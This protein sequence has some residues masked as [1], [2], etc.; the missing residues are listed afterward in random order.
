MCTGSGGW[1]LYQTMFRRTRKETVNSEELCHKENKARYTFILLMMTKSVQRK[2]IKPVAR[3]KG[4]SNL[5]LGS[6]T[7]TLPYYR[8][9]D[10]TEGG[11]WECGRFIF[12]FPECGINHKST[13]NANR[14]KR[15]VLQ[16]KA[17][18]PTTSQNNKLKIHSQVADKMCTWNS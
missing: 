18:T 5:E 1:G 4:A 12:D 13:R 8:T 17:T 10:L 14:A 9:N 3:Q 11:G 15:S 2:Q 16:S 6:H 7:L